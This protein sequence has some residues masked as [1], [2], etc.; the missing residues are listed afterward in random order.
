M[1]AILYLYITITL[2]I[3]SC[4]KVAMDK[5]FPLYVQNQSS[6]SINVF[7]ND[8][9]DNFAIYP[10]TTISY[11]QNGIIEIPSSEKQAVAGGSANWES[12]FKVSVPGDT[13][14]VF[15]FHTDT[16]SKYSWS[17]IRKDYNILKR[18]DLSLGDLQRLNFVVTYPPDA[19]MGGVRM[20]PPE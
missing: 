1:R 7:L 15:V 13:L 20:Y 8:N 10:D 4:E 6:H 2:G 14:S 17:Q 16:L 19:S 12:V 18:Y 11:V 9:D 5:D 3:Q